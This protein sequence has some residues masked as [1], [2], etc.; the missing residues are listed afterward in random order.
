[1]AWTIGSPVTTMD[2]PFLETRVDIGVS[3][4]G[5]SAV[6]HGGARAPKRV[7]IVPLNTPARGGEQSIMLELVTSSLTAAAAVSAVEFEVTSTCS[8]AYGYRIFFTFADF[9]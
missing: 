4:V 5:P 9:A 1:M 6:P 3:E 7:T 2:H 8:A